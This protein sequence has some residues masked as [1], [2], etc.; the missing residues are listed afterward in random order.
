MVQEISCTRNKQT[1]TDPMS[2]GR[3]HKDDPVKAYSIV[4]ASRD[5]KILHGY[6][7]LHIHC[8][9]QY[10]AALPDRLDC[11]TGLTVV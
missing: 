1:C 6:T 8:E 4:K 5:C 3:W 9:H 7:G 10:I 11:A 2:Y